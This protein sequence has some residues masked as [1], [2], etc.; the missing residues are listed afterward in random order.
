MISRGLPVAHATAKKAAMDTG[1]C[2]ACDLLQQQSATS[3]K[4]SYASAIE[5]I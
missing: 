2:D 3:A 4:I 5:Y 1:A